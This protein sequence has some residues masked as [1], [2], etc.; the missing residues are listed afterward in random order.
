MFGA[1]AHVHLF[2]LV[3]QNYLYELEFENKYKKTEVAVTGD[4]NPWPAAVGK[5]IKKWERK[6]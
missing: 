4:G 3:W 5:E 6:D 2:Y 1:E